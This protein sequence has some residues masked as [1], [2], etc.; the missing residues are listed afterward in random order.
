MILRIPSGH[1][2]GMP[3]CRHLPDRVRTETSLLIAELAVQGFQLERGV[4]PDQLE[5]LLPEF[6]SELP[7]DPFDPNGRPLRYLRTGTEHVLCSIGG[8]GD[9]DR[10]RPPTRDKGGGWAP[11][12]DGDLRLDFLFPS[13]DDSD[14]TEAKANE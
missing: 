1:L 4:L 11:K 8:D 5:Q 10:G 12:S 2:F 14:D 7:V 6:L 13:H 3:T 9:D